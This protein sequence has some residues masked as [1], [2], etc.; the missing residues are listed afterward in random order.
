[1]LIVCCFFFGFLWFEGFQT[2]YAYCTRFQ[3]HYANDADELERC[4]FF[5]K[6]NT[7]AAKLNALN[8]EPVFGITSMSKNPINCVET[9]ERVIA[10]R[11]EHNSH[12]VFYKRDVPEGMRT[13]WKL[14]V[15]VV[16]KSFLECV[17]LFKEF[18]TAQDETSAELTA[19]EKNWLDQKTN[20]QGLM[21]AEM[22]PRSA[23][24]PPW[25][26]KCNR[27]REFGVAYTFVIG[28]RGYKPRSE[29]IQPL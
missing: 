4:G 11:E 12:I 17:N 7:N 8:P 1:M 22:Q 24:P 15:D 14:P 28:A 26:D 9:I 3:K 21:K 23:R 19:L 6:S 2:L 10:V 16:S 29:E 27:G 20:H 13:P 25:R 5:E 18:K